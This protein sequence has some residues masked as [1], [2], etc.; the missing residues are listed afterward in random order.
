MATRPPFITRA[1]MPAPQRGDRATFSDRVDR[2]VTWMSAAPQE[3]QDLSDNVYDNAVAA[4][5]S[6]NAAAAAASQADAASGSAFASSN[7]ASAS[8]NSA[9]ASENSA[10]ASAT[11]AKASSDNASAVTG[12]PAITGNAQ[13]SLRVNAAGTAMEW[14]V[15]GNALGFVPVRQGGGAGQDNGTVAIGRA[16]GTAALLKATVAGTDAGYIPTSSTSP[17]SKVTYGVPVAATSFEGSG[18]ALTGFTAGQVNT[19]LGYTAA[20]QAKIVSG[21]TPVGFTSD[22]TGSVLRTVRAK[23]L[24]MR[25]SIFDYGAGASDTANTQAVPLAGEAVKYPGEVRVLGYDNRFGADLVPTG[26]AHNRTSG[27]VYNPRQQFLART[28]GQETL[29]HWFSTFY[30]ASNKNNGDSTIRRIVISGDSTTFGVGATYGTPATLLEDLAEARGFTNVGIVNRGQS[31]KATF[32]WVNTY[33]A[34][35]LA[36]NPNLLILRWGANDP[37][38]GRTPE[39]FITDLRQ[40]LT[41]IRASKSAAQLS[42]LLMT[43]TSMNDVEKG[44]TEVWSEQIGPAIRQAAQDFQCAFIDSYG[45]FQN[46]HDAAGVWMDKDTTFYAPGRAIHPYDVLYEHLCGTIADMIY[47]NWGTDWRTNAVRNCSAGDIATLKTGAELP[48]AYLSGI[49]MHRLAAAVGTPNGNPYDGVAF[50]FKQA[51][52]V[53]MQISVPRLDAQSGTGMSMRIGFNNTWSEWYG[54]VSAGASLLAGGW[55]NIGGGFAPFTYSLTLEGRNVLNGV[56]AAGTKTDGTILFQMPNGHRPTA[57]EI[58]LVATENGTC[59]LQVGVDGFARIF[60]FGSGGNY[61]SLS[62][63]SYKCGLS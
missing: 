46:S 43:P 15:D 54:G 37:Y 34:G 24:E 27:R 56:I 17:A 8:A 22:G 28:F 16:T 47:P 35:D 61:I 2:W 51:D 25:K 19:A 40:G 11:S 38:F 32:D 60:G 53:A 23:L 62:G 48:S 10:A 4:F 59:K 50:T 3:F 45:F 63:V 26:A 29:Q 52:G 20:D 13:R 33:L 12:I 21:A 9:A 49:G 36:A 58:L 31:G 14:V 57:T 5:D 18:A 42:V 7:A 55:S 39:Q 1:P 41:T 6:A 44:R 30:G